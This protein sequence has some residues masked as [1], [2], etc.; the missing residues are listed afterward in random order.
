MEK[1]RGALSSCRLPLPIWDSAFFRLHSPSIRFPEIMHV[2]GDNNVIET[3]ET[4][5]CSCGLENDILTGRFVGGEFDN[6]LQ[7]LTVGLTWFINP[8]FKIMGNWVFETVGEDMIGST[9][10]RRGEDTSQNLWM[11]RTQLDF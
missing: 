1:L 11:V 9:R 7:A 4:S 3:F 8:K 10:L 2:R 5:V 6:D